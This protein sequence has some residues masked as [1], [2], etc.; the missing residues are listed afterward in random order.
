MDYSRLHDLYKRDGAKRFT[1]FVVND[2]INS[3]KMS[4]EEFSLKAMWEA[5]DRPDLNAGR[6][7]LGVPI[8]EQDFTEAMDS[9][10]FPKITG[11][12]I[13]R[14]VQ[15]AYDLET[16]VGDNLVTV[17]PSSQRDDI[18]V[19]FTSDDTVEEVEEGV[20]YQE[21]YFGEKYHKIHNRKFGRI[22]SLTEEMVKFDQTGQMVQRAQRVGA[23]AAAKREE[24]I[25][26]A[27]LGTV[28]SGVN[29]SW[30]PQGTATTLYSNTSNDPFTSGTQDNLTTDALADETDLDSAYALLGAMK[31]EAGK[32]MGI[33]P[34]DLLTSYSK[35]GIGQKIYGST[36][37]V[38][39]SKNASV[40]NNWAGVVRPWASSW[41]TSELGANYWFVG[42]FKKQFYYT[43]VFPLQVFQAK[44]GNEDEF[45]RDV[46]YRFKARFMGG[47]GAVSNRYVIEST[48]AA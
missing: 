15:E 10:A 17:I 13:N 24:I 30:R 38:V 45:E 31:D 34:T 21:G 32:P 16:G 47:C 48:G 2:L 27:I 12:L 22:I 20:P 26:K 14:V 28:T 8:Q 25:M 9:S 1:R 46:V 44:P 40:K 4:T 3:G 36:G 5:M 7:L 29:A 37:S 33:T 11:A 6:R 39:S 18:V 42:A 19:G 23:A 35:I 43:E 41:V